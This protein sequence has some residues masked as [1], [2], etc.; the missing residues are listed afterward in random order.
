MNDDFV[1]L[2][3]KLNSGKIIST[4][5]PEHTVDAFIDQLGPDNC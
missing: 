5:M 4:L 2:K 3:F 1:K